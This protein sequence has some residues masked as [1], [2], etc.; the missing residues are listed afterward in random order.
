M[1]AADPE[2]IRVIQEWVHKAEGD[3][4]PI[5]LAEAR[6]AVKIARRVRRQVRQHLPRE[7][8]KPLSD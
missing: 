8:L 4:E 6:V 3:Y 1:L 7:S 2:V 5:P